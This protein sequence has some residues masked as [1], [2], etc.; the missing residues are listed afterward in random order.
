MR[1]SCFTN[2]LLIAIFSSLLSFYVYAGPLEDY[3]NMPDSSYT[4]TITTQE[5]SFTHT[6]YVVDLTSQT[7]RSPSEVNRTLWK[8][9]LTIIVPTSITKTKGLLVISGGNNGSPATNLRD[10]AQYVALLTGAPVALLEQ[11]P[12]Q[13]LRFAGE[14]FSRT[15]DEIIAYS[16]D[17]YLQTYDAGT[18]DPYWPVLLPMV[19]SAVRAMDTIQE[20]VL[21]NHSKTIN[22]FV[23]GGASKRGWTTW[24]TAAADSRVIAIAPIVIDVLKM[25]VQMDHHYKCYGFFAP[26]LKPYNDLHIFERMDTPGGY[27]LRQIVDPYSY[28]NRYT[29]P[30]YIINACGDEF[31]LPDSSRFYYH[32]LPGECRLKYT[33]NVGH[34]MGDSFDINTVLPLITYFNSVAGIG[35]RPNYSW[36]FLPDGSIQVQVATNPTSVKLWQATNPNARDFRYLGG[37]GPQWTSTTLSETYPGSKTYLAQVTPPE[38]GWKAYMVEINFSNGSYIFTTDIGITP[39]M[40]PYDDLDGDGWMDPEDTDDDCD[41]M[42]DEDDPY[43]WDTDNDGT[44]NYLDDTPGICFVEVPYVVG[45]PEVEATT[46]ILETGLFVGNITYICDNT[47]H[48]GVV[49]DQEPTAGTGVEP[50]TSVDLWIS[51]GPCPQEGEGTAEGIIEGE[52]IPE[53]EGVTEGEGIVEGTPEGEGVTEG[54]GIVEGTPEGEG[55]IE[56]EGVVEGTPEGEGI[57][58]G[59][60]VVEGTPEGEGIIEGEGVVEGTPE[61][62]GIIEGEGVVEGTPEGEGIIEGE[63]VVEGTPEGEGTIEGEGVVEGTPEGEGII[64]GEGVVEG[65]PEGEGTIEGEGVVEGTPEGEGNTEG[66]QEG[67]LGPVRHS[68]DTNGNWKIELSELLRV[69]QFFNSGGYHCADEPEDTEDGYIPGTGDNKLCKPH[70]SDYNPQD[71]NIQLTELLRLIQ[72]FNSGGFSY[73]PE[74]ATEDNYCPNI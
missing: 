8:H 21:N 26:T 63:G 51:T 14:S 50:G 4:Y 64:E 19:K 44:P 74:M 45:L 23:V 6:Y 69:I 28:L 17:K 55:I 29:M 48:A 37:S 39:Y 40:R 59:E 2:Y 58:E 43:P 11:V 24:L 54:E 61:G 35:T 68:A 71:W 66:T 65:T 30:K 3:V 52:G 53:G 36:Q 1:K 49:V 13:P 33:P 41:L 70:V 12:N 27:A 31:F 72:F 7:W 47:F 22:G 38:T 73:C 62:E 60:G 16:Y 18:P 57:I 15:E 67:E 42:L 20:I 9:W 32:E 25:D 34:S 46:D 56:G 5:S 10:Y